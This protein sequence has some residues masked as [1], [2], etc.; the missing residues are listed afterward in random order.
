MAVAS[1]LPYEAAG[2][3]GKSRGAGACE[4]VYGARCPYSKTDMMQIIA[5]VWSSMGVEE[6]NSNVVSA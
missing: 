3:L 4:V 5:S 1:K 6:A 2:W